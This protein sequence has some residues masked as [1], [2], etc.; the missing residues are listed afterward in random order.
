[1]ALLKYLA[2]TASELKI[3]KSKIAQ[4]QKIVGKVSVAG[5][6]NQTYTTKRDVKE[7]VLAKKVGK[8]YSGEYSRP[9]R[10]L[11]QDALCYHS[12]TG[13]RGIQANEE[14]KEKQ[15]HIQGCPRLHAKKTG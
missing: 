5:E 9:R 7:N 8:A 13:G 2:S 3:L 14:A 4:K 12:R 11:H 15:E 1:M 10:T 6:Y